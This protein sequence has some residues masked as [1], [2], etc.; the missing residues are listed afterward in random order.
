MFLSIGL[1]LYS[2]VQTPSSFLS[3]LVSESICTRRFVSLYTME[4]F[5]I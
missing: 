1:E 5:H 2:I 4:L 3:T